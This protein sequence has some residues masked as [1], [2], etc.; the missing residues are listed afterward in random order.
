MTFSI[1]TNSFCYFFTVDI[2]TYYGIIDT[3][4]LNG[5]DM[6]RRKVY[7]EV[8]LRQ[9]TDGHKRPL[10]IRWE[11]GEVYEID[12]LKDVRLAASL[13]V[14]GYGWRYTVFI[15]GKETYLFEEDNRWFVEAKV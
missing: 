7:V 10:S 8:V 12:R 4:V 6:Y 3:N 11:D 14:G 1:W 2:D 15:E 13:K 5:D 9:D